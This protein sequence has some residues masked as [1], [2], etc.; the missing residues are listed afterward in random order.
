MKASSR[1]A[2]CCAIPDVHAL[3]YQKGQIRF[4]LRRSPEIQ[5]SVGNSNADMVIL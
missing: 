5:F 4:A 2:G 1:L 3:R